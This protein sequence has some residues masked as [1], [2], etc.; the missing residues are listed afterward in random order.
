MTYKDDFAIYSIHC[1]NNGITIGIYSQILRCR[2][3]RTVSWQL[4]YHHRI[5]RFFKRLILRLPRHKAQTTPLE[6]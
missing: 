3:V 5:A 6:R 2:L 1:V 4:Y